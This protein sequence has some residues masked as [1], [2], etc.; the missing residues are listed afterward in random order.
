MRHIPNARRLAR[1]A[2]TA[3]GIL[4]TGLIAGPAVLAQDDGTPPAPPTISM[5]VQGKRVF[6]DAPDTVRTGEKLTIVNNTNPRRIGPHTF[7]LA[8]PSVLPH[9]G[10]EFK[11]CFTPGKICMDIAL[12]H[13][14]NPR[15]E[16]IN[17]P[18][19]NVGAKGWN[20][21]FT[22]KRKGDSWYTET[23]GEEFVRRVSASAGTTL[24]F[25]CAVHPNMQGEIKV[26]AAE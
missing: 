11:N 24:T 21:M 2:T 14:F 20:R 6:F 15:T 22:K 3:C 1:S 8:K 25:L 4:V 9:G 16:K 19:V 5:E 17:K 23:K 7:S 26:V 13:K 12:A 18:I 10:K